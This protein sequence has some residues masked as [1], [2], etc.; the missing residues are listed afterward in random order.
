MADDKQ[1]M[2]CWGGPKW[3]REVVADHKVRRLSCRPQMLPDPVL[4]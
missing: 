3:K 2:S 4:V 1:N